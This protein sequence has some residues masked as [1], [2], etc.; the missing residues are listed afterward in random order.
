MEERFS[1][2]RLV[3][4]KA[5]EGFCGR[6]GFTNGNIEG[7]LI[8][9]ALNGAV[10][11]LEGCWAVWEGYDLVAYAN[12]KM[13]YVKSGHAPSR[14]HQMHKFSVRKAFDHRDVPEPGG[15]ERGHYCGRAASAEREH[16]GEV[17]KSELDFRSY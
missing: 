4:A 7:N 2:W 5:L 6:Q 10:G 14:Q 9:S 12:G 8:L 3:A 15:Q 1:G 13:E 11:A 16:S 17:G